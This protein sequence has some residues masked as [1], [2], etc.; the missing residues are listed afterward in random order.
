MNTG[1]AP[2]PDVKKEIKKQQQKMNKTRGKQQGI[3]TFQTN[4]VRACEHTRLGVIDFIASVPKLLI[5]LNW[6]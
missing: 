6:T 3:R 2:Y 4:L 1:A 5:T